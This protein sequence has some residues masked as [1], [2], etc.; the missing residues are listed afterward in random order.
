MNTPSQAPPVL[1][2]K[3]YSE[4]EAEYRKAEDHLA[5]QDLHHKEHSHVQQPP[6][7]RPL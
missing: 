3:E 1:S 4:L 7:S 5:R 2:D 6:N